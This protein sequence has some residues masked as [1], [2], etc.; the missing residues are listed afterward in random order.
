MS[1]MAGHVKLVHHVLPGLRPLLFQIADLP[2]VA[3]VIPGEVRTG[4]TRR[5]QDPL[6]VQAETQDGL[7]LR[8]RTPRAVQ[9]VFVVTTEPEGVRQ[10][11]KETRR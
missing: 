2:G 9:D 3:R 8:Y 1:G 5:V 10:L 7:R 4:S 6:R 11:A